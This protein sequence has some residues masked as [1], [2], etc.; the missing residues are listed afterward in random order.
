MAKEN[1]SSASLESLRISNTV[2][3]RRFLQFLQN[4]VFRIL[5]NSVRWVIMVAASG[6]SPFLLAANPSEKNARVLPGDS[7]CDGKTSLKWQWK[8]NA[9]T[10]ER[11]ICPNK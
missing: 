2:V 6:E 7:R 10:L 5:N 11:G 3:G 1:S 9:G 8:R 4:E